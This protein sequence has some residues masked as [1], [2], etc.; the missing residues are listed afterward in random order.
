[1]IGRVECFGN[2]TGLLDCSH[3]TEAHEEV[4]HCDPIKVAAVTCNGMSFISETFAST[5]V[6]V[7][8]DPSTALVDCVTGEVRFVDISNN[9]EEDSRQGTIQICVNNA[10]GSVCSDDFFDNTDAAA[11]CKQLPGFSPDGSGFHTRLLGK[12]NLFNDRCL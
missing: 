6:C 10:W 4:I 7:S 3:V 2:E 12:T 9:P 8:I 5:T 11:F 1:M